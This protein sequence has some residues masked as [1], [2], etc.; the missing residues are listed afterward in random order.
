M[1]CRVKQKSIQFALRIMAMI[2]NASYLLLL[3]V[4]LGTSQVK[5]SN[6]LTSFLKFLIFSFSS[7]STSLNASTRGTQSTPRTFCFLKTISRGL[8]VLTSL[9]DLVQPLDFINA[10]IATLMKSSANTYRTVVFNVSFEVCAAMSGEYSPII[11]FVLPL[12]SKF[13]PDFIHECPYQGR[14]VGVSNLPIDF[15]LMP[16]VQLSN[17]P[18]GDYR[19]VR[20][21]I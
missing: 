9:S 2:I 1:S 18:K 13:A 7:Q 3:F 10:N 17:V 19:A 14:K 21:Y 11:K 4:S 5:F 20:Q 6:Q 16:L 12:L 15:S 8:N